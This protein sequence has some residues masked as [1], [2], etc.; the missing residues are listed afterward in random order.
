MCKS[1]REKAYEAKRT[2]DASFRCLVWQ[3]PFGFNNGLTKMNNDFP[4]RGFSSSLTDKAYKGMLEDT[5]Q[6]LKWR[7]GLTWW[8]CQSHHPIEGEGSRFKLHSLFSCLHLH[9]PLKQWE[10]SVIYKNSQHTQHIIFQSR[11]Y[12]RVKKQVG[13]LSLLFRLFPFYEIFIHLSQ[14]DICCIFHF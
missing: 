8:G 14:T 9:F 1:E 5:E 2:Y 4:S 13:L 11:L 7:H 10:P 3:K 12:P 6:S